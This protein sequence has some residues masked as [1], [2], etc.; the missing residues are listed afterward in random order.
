MRKRGQRTQKDVTSI[1]VGGGAAA[2]ISKY[3]KRGAAAKRSGQYKKGVAAATRI[4]QN[5]MQGRCRN[6]NWG[7]KSGAL[8]QREMGRIKSGGAA[9]TRTEAV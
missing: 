4:C 6:E 1:K 8:P 5:K 7:K 9:A 3:K 2:R